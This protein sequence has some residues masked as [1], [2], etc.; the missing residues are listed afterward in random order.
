MASP[1]RHISPNSFDSQ[2]SSANYVVCVMPFVNRDLY[3]NKELIKNKVDTSLKIREPYII[4]NDAVKITISNNKSSPTDSS[5][6][7]LL[8]GD[9][10]YAAAFAPGDHVMIWLMNDPLTFDRISKDV[11]AKK[12]GVNTEDSGLKFVGRISSIRQQLQTDPTSGKQTYRFLVT[13]NGFSEL[14]TQIYFNELLDPTLPSANVAAKSLGWFVEVSEQYRS[15]FKSLKNDGRLKT[16]AVLKFFLDVF[17]GNGPKDKAKQVGENLVRTPNASLLV[18][19]QLAKYLN[20]TRKEEKS[21][22]IKYADII[23]RIFGIQQY[24]SNNKSVSQK[25]ISSSLDDFF[26]SNVKNTGTSVEYICDPLKG[27]ISIP[28]GN[29]NNVSLWSLLATYSNPSINELY[30]TLKYVPNKGILPTVTLRQ[31]AFTSDK[32]RQ[33]LGGTATFYSS[34]PRWKLDNNYPIMNYNIGT[35]DAERFNFFQIYTTSINTNNPQANIN[36]QITQGNMDIDDADIYRSG[37]R[38]HSSMS[39]T[40]AGA[41]DTK[42]DITNIKTWIALISDWFANGHLKMNGSITVAGIQD[43]ICIGDNLEF[44][45]KLFH[46]EAINHSMEVMPDGKK[47]FTT[48]LALSRGFYISKDGSLVYAAQGVNDFR[49]AGAPDVLLPGYSDS[50]LHVDDKFIESS[51]K[52]AVDNSQNTK[53]EIFTRANASSS[54]DKIKE[55]FLKKF[56]GS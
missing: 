48:S 37:P 32:M 10:N 43:P 18:P 20:I 55:D 34:L 22:G 3:Y 54:V 42:Y 23:Q 6:M 8:S 14:Q 31:M 46:I 33:K 50:E 25:T 27:G 38:I 53:D 36:L 24:N 21:L 9:I 39:D 40:D 11:A 12:N 51:D 41:G 56:K 30:T 19:A 5:E 4:I 49:R 45:G 26:P 16:E 29:F 52:F 47:S 1:V 13:M 15:L 28:A 44:D 2:Q 17:I 7:M 35:S